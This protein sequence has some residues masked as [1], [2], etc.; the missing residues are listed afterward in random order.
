MWN[1]GTIIVTTNYTLQV[2]KNTTNKEYTELSY[3]ATI[4][5]ELPDYSG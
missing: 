3:F 1:L 2:S 4:V 5:L